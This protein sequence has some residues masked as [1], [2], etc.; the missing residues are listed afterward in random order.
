MF[1]IIIQSIWFFLPGYFANAIPVFLAK[2]RLFEFM[3]IPVDFG[4]KWSHE[5][6]FG[7][8][9]TFRG[10]IG[11]IFVAISIS[12]LQYFIFIVFPVLNSL[13]LFNYQIP[14]ILL[15]GFLQGLGVGL[16]DLIKSFFKRRFH[17]K[18]GAPFVPFDQM[19]FLGGLVLS[20]FVFIP[21]SAHI[22]TIILI[23]LPL[24]LVANLFAYKIGWKNVWW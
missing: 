24:P 4:I 23:S 10:I 18:S 15:L 13:F 21:S 22:L 19:D 7:Q 1:A 2:Y 14:D 20:F 5:R 17:L 6:L 16:C 8:N 11:G 9:K 3:N 12:I